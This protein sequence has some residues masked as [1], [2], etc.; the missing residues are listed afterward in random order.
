M[1]PTV[2]TPALIMTAAIE[3]KEGREVATSTIPN[4]FIQMEQA[5]TDKEREWYTLKIRGKPAHLLVEIDPETY[6]PYLTKENGHDIIYV[7]VLKA[8]YC[9]LQSALLFYKKLCM[10]LKDSGF[11]VNDYNPCLA[12]K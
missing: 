3:A 4:A 2:S 9:M 11:K 5:K 6:K 12:N 1:S 8:I 7:R 10:D